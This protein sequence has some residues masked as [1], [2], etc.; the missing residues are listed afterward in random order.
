MFD[1]QPDII[2]TILTEDT[3]ETMI[4]FTEDGGISSGIHGMTSQ[5]KFFTLVESNLFEPETTG[6]A[7][8]VSPTASRL[9]F[10]FQNDGILYE[11]QRTDG[12]SFR[13]AAPN[14]KAHS[15]DMTDDRRQRERMFFR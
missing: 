14:L 8:H 2:R 7:V 11:L 6:L 5:G 1:G 4:Y 12:K 15:S 10:S 13:G 9:Y 3:K